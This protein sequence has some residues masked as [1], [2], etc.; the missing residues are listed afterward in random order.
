[1]KRAPDVENEQQRQF[2]H[3]VFGADRE[4]KITGKP[5]Y[6]RRVFWAVPVRPLPWAEAALAIS[7][8]ELAADAAFALEMLTVPTPS[9]EPPEQPSR[10]V[11]SIA[12]IV[13]STRRSSPCSRRKV[14]RRLMIKTLFMNIGCIGTLLAQHR[15]AARVDRQSLPTSFK[16][17]LFS[18]TRTEAK[19]TFRVPQKWTIRY[20]VTRDY[21]GCRNSYQEPH[22]TD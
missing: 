12:T 4:H 6:F 14:A 3:R 11:T 19:W 5:P 16:R 18:G 22:A 7:G 17:V 20:I 2:V 1:M 15:R 21:R 10:I 8:F 9:V 13:A